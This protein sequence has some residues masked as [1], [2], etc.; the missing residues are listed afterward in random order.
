MRRRGRPG[1]A[2]P[3]SRPRLALRDVGLLEAPS[4]QG[5]ERLFEVARAETLG[6]LLDRALGDE[7]AAVDDPDAVREPLRL[8]EVVRR[9]QDRCVVLV[10]QVADERLHFPLADYDGSGML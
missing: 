7:T 10:A 8:V 9:Q 1:R 4:G 6:Q 3:R 5:H 2:A